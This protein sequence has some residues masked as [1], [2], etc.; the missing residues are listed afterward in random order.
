LW[1]V[2]FKADLKILKTSNENSR[3][4]RTA[5]YWYAPDRTYTLSKRESQNSAVCPKCG[6]VLSLEPFTR[7]EKLYV[8]SNAECKWKI[9]KSKVVIKVK[10]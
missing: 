4:H 1:A 5:L 9:P 2:D 6:Q 3:R 8:C 10:L 7:S